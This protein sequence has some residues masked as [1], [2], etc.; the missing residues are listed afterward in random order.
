[1]KVIQ[2]LT[3]RHVKDRATD[4]TGDI[5]DRITQRIVIVNGSVHEE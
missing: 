5:N 3:K 4:L 1:M 2:W